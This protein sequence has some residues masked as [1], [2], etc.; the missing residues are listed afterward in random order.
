LEGAGFGTALALGWRVRFG[1]SSITSESSLDESSASSLSDAGL[2]SEPSSGTSESAL[3]LSVGSFDCGFSVGF[4]DSCS[5]LSPLES[6]RLSS[7]SDTTFPF[8][9]DVNLRFLGGGEGASSS[10]TSLISDSTSEG[11]GAF[12]GR[13]FSLLLVCL[14]AGFAFFF[15]VGT[16][17][18][19]SPASSS[20]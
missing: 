11:V 17:G 14:G 15:G 3:S 7:S 2:L 1:G 6:D 20:F 18:S 19:V 10:P 4:A 8:L 12:F 16:G 9:F 5:L 13:F